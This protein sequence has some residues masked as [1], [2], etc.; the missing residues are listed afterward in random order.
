[1]IRCTVKYRVAGG[2][3]LLGVLAF[4]CLTHRKHKSNSQGQ[5]Q[6]APAPDTA[7]KQGSLNS[8]S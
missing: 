4:V 7:A 2:L 5:S 6:S 1:L 8:I 3:I